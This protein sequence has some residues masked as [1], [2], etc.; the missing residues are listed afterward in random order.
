MTDN[1]LPLVSVVI[2]T[3]NREHLIVDALDSVLAQGYRPL[4]LVV[5]DDG[6]E[7]NTESVVL[8]W[9]EENAGSLQSG[10]SLHYVK[11]QNQ[12]GNVARNRGIRE[13]RGEYIAFLDSDD[14]WD[15]MKLEKQCQL[16][17]KGSDVAAV[18]CG[19]RHMDAAT[20]K[21]TE[22]PPRDYPRG[23]LLDEMLVHDVTAPT[24]TYIVRRDVFSKVGAFDETLQ[25]RQDWDMWIRV[26]AHGDIEALPEALVQFRSHDGPRTASN[27]MREIRAYESIIEKYASL[28]AQ[29]PARVRRLSKAAFHRR[30][31]RVHFHNGLGRWQALKHYLAAIFY[32]PLVFDSYAALLGWFIPGS[33]RR[34][35][36][37]V[38]NGALGSTRLAIR[39]H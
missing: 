11:Q 24:S 37:R 8:K 39:S 25:A 20:G 18:Y 3:F 14:C 21:V 32:G 33:L 29:R 5:V 16:F 17:G 23:D 15:A 22:A 36:H 35:L 1:S 27:P 6:S 19:V 38:W 4:Q 7:D 26:S 34:G 2:P 31:G 10:F 12:G 9:A 28:R 13:S 30:L